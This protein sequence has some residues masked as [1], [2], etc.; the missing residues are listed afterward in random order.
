[1]HK[2]ISK[3]LLQTSTFGLACTIALSAHADIVLPGVTVVGASL[4]GEEISSNQVGSSVSVITAEDIE[5][6]KIRNV[7]DALR[8]LPGVSV[9][10]T[11]TSA[12]ISQVRIR[13]AEANHTLVII[14][15][16]EV[17]AASGGEFDFSNLSATDIERIEVIRGPQSGIYGSNALAGVINITTK[18]GKGPLR[19]TLRAEAGSFNTQAG[20]LSISAGNEKGYAS[21]SYDRYKTDGF[22]ISPTGSEEDGSERTSVFFRGGYRP[23]EN[24]NIDFMLRNVEKKGDRDSDSNFDGIQDDLGSFRPYFSS[25][26]FVIG[27]SAK[28]NTFDG[29]WTHKLSAN[30]QSTDTTDVSA[31]GPFNNNSETTKLSYLST[32]KFDTEQFLNGKHS[33]TGLVEYEEDDFDVVGTFSNRQASRERTSYALELKSNLSDQ[34]SLSANVRHDDNRASKDF[35]TYRVA[36]SWQIPQTGLRLHSNIG[37]GVKFPTMFE[38]FGTSAFFTSNPNVKPEESFGWDVGLEWSSKDKKYTVDVTY[39]NQ[40]LKNE[41]YTTFLP[42]FTSTVDNRDGDSERSGIEVSLT[43]NISSTLSVTGGYTYLD[44]TDNNGVQEIRRPK[45]SGKINVNYGFD[46]GK[47]NLN[48]G[49]N[50]NGNARDTQFNSP[51]FDTPVTLDDYVLVSLAGSYQVQPNIELFGKV[52]NVLDEDYQEVFGFETAGISAYAGVKIKL[53]P[54][55]GE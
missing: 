10:Q 50:Y 27:L 8:N 31:F 2:L 15:G 1:M 34:L 11:S 32:I 20:G 16:V 19:A 51:T 30:K 53:G 44:A 9:N 41:I 55:D 7:T 46:N 49:V 14:D 4:D 6:Q 48:V 38:Q 35:T 29:R 47:G 13:G 42:D 54:V 25:D 22:N 52:E 26:L 33:L 36:G 17:N 24:L 12:S 3:Y 43:A 45:H 40:D 28:L 18:K 21:F 37:T 5:R 23:L 39:F